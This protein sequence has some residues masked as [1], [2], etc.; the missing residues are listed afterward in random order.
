MR[1]N[2]TPPSEWNA[3]FQAIGRIV[4]HWNNLERSA[5]NLL[6]ELI[7]AG[8]KATIVTAHMNSNVQLDALKT[9]AAEFLDEAEAESVAH[10]IRVIER[11][12][13]RRNHYVH[14]FSVV[15]VLLDVSEDQSSI[16]PDPFQAVLTNVHARGRLRET[17][18]IVSAAHLM[19]EADLFADAS[20]YANQLARHFIDSAC[21]GYEPTLPE[22]FPLPD[23]LT[24]PA[25]F[26]LDDQHP[27]RSSPL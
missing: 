11:L 1:E 4:Y 2:L 14:A 17:T 20:I 12:R 22:K 24:K 27:L 15:T 6:N 16:A 26:V 5:L 7:G 18:Q 13:E 21:P 19:N 25:R 23:T 8:A 10:F 9:I 3:V